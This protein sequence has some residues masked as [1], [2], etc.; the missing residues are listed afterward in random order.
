MSKLRTRAM[1]KQQT[2]DQHKLGGCPGY[3]PCTLPCT[4]VKTNPLSK[5][6]NPSKTLESQ[7]VD[8]LPDSNEVFDDELSTEDEANSNPADEIS[9][10]LAILSYYIPPVGLVYWLCYRKEL[11]KRAKACGTAALTSFRLLII[12]I[13]CS[14]LYL[15]LYTISS[16]T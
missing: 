9:V 10:W 14:L 5:T 1:N 11:P 6:V 13:F 4:E 12:S 2:A 16:R 3:L 7:K 15:V 8:K